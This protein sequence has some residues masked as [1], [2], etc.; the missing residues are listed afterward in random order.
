MVRDHRAS[1]ADRVRD[2]LPRSARRTRFAPTR[3]GRRAEGE[4]RSRR[5]GARCRG[6]GT[7]SRRTRTRT[8]GGRKGLA[9]GDAR[10]AARRIRLAREAEAA[11]A[12]WARG[13]RCRGRTWRARRARSK[14]SSATSR[15]SKPAC[16]KSPRG[17]ARFAGRGRRAG[18][19]ADCRSSRGSSRGGGRSARS[20]KNRPSSGACADGENR[21]DG[22]R[23][24]PRSPRRASISA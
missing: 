7:R 6:G 4:G 18:A 8:R 1:D 13:R 22:R 24:R 20:S 11:L 17:R 3:L 15:N 23:L 19:R 14:A 21:R 12:A 2:R 10:F 16:S 5:R 9:A